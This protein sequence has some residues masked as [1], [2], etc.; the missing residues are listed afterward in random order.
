M[1]YEFGRY[2]LLRSLQ[3]RAEALGHEICGWVRDDGE[4]ITGCTRCGARI[5]ARVNTP[6]VTDGEALSEVCASA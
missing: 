4:S 1:R 2:Q 3:R 6:P 5:Y